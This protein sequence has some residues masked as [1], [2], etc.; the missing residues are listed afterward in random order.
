M[1]F[2]TCLPFALLL[3]HRPSGRKKTAGDPL[4]AFHDAIECAV[5]DIQ[6]DWEY[7]YSDEAV[8]EMLIINEYEFT[9]DGKRYA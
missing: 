2:T 8:E 5:T 6:K 7:Q 9:E 1:K 3:N 4:K